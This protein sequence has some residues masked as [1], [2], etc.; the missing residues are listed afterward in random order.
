METNN[1]YTCI[2]DYDREHLWYGT[3]TTVIATPNLQHIV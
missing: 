3:C 1:D 2:G